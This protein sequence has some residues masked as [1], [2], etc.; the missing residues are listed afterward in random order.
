MKRLFVLPLLW[1]VLAGLPAAAQEKLYPVTRFKDIPVV[2]SPDHS[3]IVIERSFQYKLTL[4]YPTSDSTIFIPQT[5]TPIVMLWLKIQNT[6]Q[7]PFDIDISKFTSV[8]DQ[9]QM[10]P[11]LSVDEA[12]KRI[13]SGF[14]GATSGSKTLKA[15]SLGHVAN[16]PSEEEFRSSLVRYSFQ[17]GPV[18]GNIQKEGWIYFEKPPRKK[19]TI[20]VTL[21]GLASQPLIFST[22]KQK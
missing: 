1:L 9:G 2:L 4:S 11:A 3:G 20:T 22:E 16:I 15:L 13:L 10:F 21:N 12:S 18:G 6:A 19:F 17:S 5:E 8:D 7:R 14:Y